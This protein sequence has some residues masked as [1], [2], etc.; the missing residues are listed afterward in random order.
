M[1]VPPYEQ[2]AEYWVKKALVIAQE[3][4]GPFGGYVFNSKC[5]HSKERNKR[6]KQDV[7]YNFIPD[8]VEPS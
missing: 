3:Y 2:L 7:P 1:H 6:Y 5:A 4:H 8:L